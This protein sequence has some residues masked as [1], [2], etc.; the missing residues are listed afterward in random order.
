MHI[1]SLVMIEPSEHVRHVYVSQFHILQ[2]S[3]AFWA[4]IPITAQHASVQQWVPLAVTHTDPPEQGSVARH[5]SYG[6]VLIA[7]ISLLIVRVYVKATEMQKSAKSML[8]R[9]ILLCRMIKLYPH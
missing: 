9:D 6:T 5:T 7:A 2:C 4:T 3:S 1:P 8:F